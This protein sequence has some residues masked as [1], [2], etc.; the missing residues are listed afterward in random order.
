[1]SGDRPYRPETLAVHLGLAPDAQTGAVVPPLHLATTFERDADGSYPR[2]FV[3]A[4]PDNP[5]RAQLER[6]LALLEGGREAA[7]F[8]SGSAAAAAVLRSVPA[9]GHAIVPDDQYHGLRTLLERVLVPAGLQVSVVDMSDLDAVAAA[10]RPSTQLVWIETPSNPLLKVTDVAG[11]VAIARAAEARHG[12][13]VAVALDATWTPPPWQPAF[14]LGV[15]LVVHA[16]TKYLAG[17]SDVLGGAVVAAPDARSVGEVWGRV[18]DVQRLEGG[19]PSPFDAWLTLRG[20]R[21]LAVRLAAQADG[22]AAVVAFLVAHPAVAQVLY[23]GLPGHPGHA[24]A[25]RQMASFGAMLSFRVHG[26]VEAAM[27][28]A[29]G[30]RLFTRAT[31][32]GG[33][34]SL[35]EHRASIEPPGG[36]TPPDLLRVSIGLEHPDDLIDD[37]RDALDALEG[38]LP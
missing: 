38:G 24:V 23:P 37:L 28:V 5:N 36:P 15:D 2:G 30:V 27:R 7:A 8:A 35:I 10:V 11:V 34:E 26:G 13:P 20:L 31:S 12:A 21:T 14:A 17:H 33:V 25:A 3:Y 18:R 9:G 22:A 29:A 6:A 1:M 19:V 32:L 4:R 16:T